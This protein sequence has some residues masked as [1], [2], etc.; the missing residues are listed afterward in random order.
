MCDRGTINAFFISGCAALGVAAS[1]VVAAA[2]A[3]ASFFGA[4]GSPAL[5]IAGGVSAVIASVLFTRLKREVRKYV[6]CMT[7]DEEKN[8]CEAQKA[9]LLSHQLSNLRGKVRKGQLSGQ[10]F[11]CFTNA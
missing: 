5:M 8:K 7:K 6:D 11:S 10:P 9:V 3:N 2:I 1:W 4:P